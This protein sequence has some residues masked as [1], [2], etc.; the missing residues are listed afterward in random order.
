MGKYP[1]FKVFAHIRFN[2]KIYKINKQ[3]PEISV[4]IPSKEVIY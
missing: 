1:V 3:D 2:E 4:L